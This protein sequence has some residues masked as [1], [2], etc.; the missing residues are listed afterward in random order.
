MT[1]F[2]ADVEKTALRHL[3]RNFHLRAGCK[4][5]EKALLLVRVQRHEV[6]MHGR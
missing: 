1:H 6:C 5:V 2:E 4:L 3:V